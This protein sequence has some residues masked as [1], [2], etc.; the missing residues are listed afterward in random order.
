[1]NRIDAKFRQLKEQKRKGFIAYIT[2]GDPDLGTTERLV[3]ALA[4]NGVDIIELGVPF[5]DPMADGPTI[6]KAA[7]RALKKKV[8]LKKIIGAVNRI[9]RKSDIPIVLFTYL[10]PVFRYGWEKFAREAGRA[11]IDG[12]LVLDLPV[13]ESEQERKLLKEYGV[14]M[15]YLTAPTSSDKRIKMITGKGEGF[16][17]YVSRTGVTGMK[18]Q[19]AKG[20]KTMVDKIKR[21]TVLPVAVGFGISRPEHVK[22]VARYADAVVVGSAI[23]A[24]IEKNIDRKDLVD[25]VGRFTAYLVGR[26]KGKKR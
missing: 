20:V 7:Q 26:N 23:V 1:M 16:I 22:Q 4:E 12:I 10:N 15:I 6:Q 19:V 13:E 3:P 24:Q 2:A 11:G 9:R 17:Y 14:E 25:R 5:S 18:R 21:Y 8:T